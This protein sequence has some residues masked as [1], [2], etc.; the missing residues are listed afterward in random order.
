MATEPQ[1]AATPILEVA[2]VTAAN[3]NRDGTG[4]IVTVASGTAAGKRISRVTIQA[5]GTTTAG[6]IRFYFSPDGGTTNRLIGEVAVTAATPS[7]TVSA[8]S[9]LATAL[10]GLILPGT[11]A[12]LRASTHNA[13]TFNILIE[14]GG[15]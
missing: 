13:E 8:F 9:T 5:T 7:G 1:F 10:V 3:T 12:Q 15:L 6:M 11:S 4:T 2:Q 14:S